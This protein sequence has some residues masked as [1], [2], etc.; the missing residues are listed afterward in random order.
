MERM[1]I[2]PM[3]PAY[4]TS[5]ARLLAAGF[6]G[7][8]MPGSQVEQSRLV[9]VLELLVPLDAAS[10]NVERVV[11]VMDGIAV[12]SLAIRWPSPTVEKA[13]TPL[14]QLGKAL[15]SIGLW[16]GLKL[17]V[18]LLLLNHTPEKQEGYIA[19]VAVDPRYRG[20]GVGHFMLEWA[21]R[22]AAKRSDIRYLSLHVSRTNHKALR[23]Y[24]QM[25]FRTQK[26]QSSSLR[27]HLLGEPDWMFMIRERETDA[28]ETQIRKNVT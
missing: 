27:G 20:Q 13:A 26:A 11:A 5:V 6:G 22:E 2:E 10:G 19:D 3:K 9:P 1:R 4:A 16:R 15:R 21:Q 23:L 25:G 14:R 7:K 12:G 24:E 17:S 28:D 8:L 18:R